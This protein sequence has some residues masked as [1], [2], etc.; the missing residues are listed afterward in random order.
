MPRDLAEKGVHA[1]RGINAETG[2][3]LLPVA[4]ENEEED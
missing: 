1:V 3:I 4:T 2:E